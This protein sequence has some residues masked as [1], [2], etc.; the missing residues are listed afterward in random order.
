[1][2]LTTNT[3]GRPERVLTQSQWA[4]PD[5]GSI[6]LFDPAAFRRSVEVMVELTKAHQRRMH[7]QYDRRRRARRR[8][9]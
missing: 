1:M 9:R 8:R 2:T 4:E 3:S 6:F 7:Q 5:H